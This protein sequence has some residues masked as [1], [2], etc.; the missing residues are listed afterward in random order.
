[1]PEEERLELTAAVEDAFSASLERLEDAL[2]DVD[3]EIAE[4]G[5][6]VNSV[7]VDTDVHIAESMGEIEAYKAQL[8]SID[9][10][11]TTKIDTEKGTEIEDMLADAQSG[12]DDLLQ[13]LGLDGGGGGGGSASRFAE[14]TTNLESSET[15]E[16][17]DALEETISSSAIG[18][19]GTNRPPDINAEDTFFRPGRSGSAPE[20]R[21]DGPSSINVNNLNELQ[22]TFGQALDKSALGEMGGEVD[23]IS[24]IVKGDLGDVIDFDRAVELADDPNTDVNLDTLQ[25]LRGRQGLDSFTD[26]I[27]TLSEASDTAGDFTN[28]TALGGNRSFS[29]RLRRTT[30]ALADFRFGIRAFNQAFAALVPIIILLVG[31]LPTIITA[32]GGLAAAAVGATVALAGIG[33]LGLAGISFAQE[34]ELALEPI[35]NELREVGDVFID[36]FRPLAETLAPTVQRALSEIEMLADPLARA[37]TSLLR[38][39]EAFVGVFAFIRKGLPSLTQG[40]LNFAEAAMPIINQVIGFFVETNFLQAFA[41]VLAESHGQ[42]TML[43]RGIADIIPFLVSFSQGFIF[44]TAAVFKLLGGTASILNTFPLVAKTLGLLTAAFVGLVTAITL[45]AIAKRGAT[46]RAYE[47]V[48]GLVSEAAAFL[49]AKLAAINY[50]ISMTTATIVT[51]TFLGL[52]TLGLIP[53][54]GVLS[55]QFNILGGNIAD[56]RKELEKFSRVGGG[57]LGSG[58]GVSAGSDSAFGNNG[59]VYRDNSTTIIDASDPDNASRQQYGSDFE[60]RQQVDS[61][62]GA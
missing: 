28:A 20:I 40:L 39:R 10:E 61:V 59:N 54:I 30:N 60:R 43:A 44:A 22:Q 1:M 13:A 7:V 16:S 37:S 42:L 58:V 46:L 56:A 38:F 24:K 53:A 36:A 47:L 19:E 48:A 51:A 17:I 8:E 31:A 21:A 41:G 4:T 29:S 2:E 14:A 27:E 57:P 3:R 45:S 50:S 11:V 12:D 15:R 23:D 9:D 55:S 25:A 49:Q 35:L 32:L 52:I 6:G 62:F 18:K 34:G 33:A 26:A 5:D